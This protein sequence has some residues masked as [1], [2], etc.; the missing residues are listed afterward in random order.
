M[1]FSAALQHDPALIEFGVEQRVIPAS[2]TTLIALLRAVAYGWRQEQLAENAQRI[3]HLGR[4]LHERIGVLADHFESL[5]KGLDGALQ[6][7]NRAVGSFEARVLVTA[8]KFKDLGAGTDDELGA[9][10]MIDRIPRQL[11]LSGMPPDEDEVAVTP[12]PNN[13]DV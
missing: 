13:T 9:L 1:F 5:R 7:Y 12:P 2:P 6:A 8:R 10:E 3:S 4:Q 11:T